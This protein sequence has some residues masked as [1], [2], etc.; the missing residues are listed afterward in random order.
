MN[1][2]FVVVTLFLSTQYNLPYPPTSLISVLTTENESR[3]NDNC[4]NPKILRLANEVVVS[5]SIE[6]RSEDLT[7]I[8]NS[9]RLLFQRDIHRSSGQSSSSRN[10]AARKAEPKAT[11]KVWNDGLSASP[12]VFD[13]QNSTFSVSGVHAILN[14]ERCGVCSLAG[15]TVRFSSSSI[16]STG[17]SSPFMVRMSG[18]EGMTTKDESI[19]VVGTGLS[20][21]STHLIGGTRPLFSFGLIEQSSSLAAS[22]CALR[23]RQADSCSEVMCVSESWELCLEAHEPRQRDRNDVAEL[24]GNVMCLTTSFSSCFR[25]PNTEFD[26]SFENHT[27]TELGRLNNV[28]S[29]VTSVTFTLCTFNEMTVVGGSGNGGAAIFLRQ[30]SSSLT[31]RT[32]FFL[33]CTCTASGIAGTIC[34]RCDSSKRRPF[35]VSDSSFTECSATQFAGSVFL[36]HSSSAAIDCCFFELSTSFWDGTALLGPNVLAPQWNPFLRRRV[37]TLHLVLAVQRLFLAHHPDGKDVFFSDNSS[38]EIT[39]DMVTFCDSS[40]RAPNVSFL[41]NQQSDSSLIPQV[42]QTAP[43]RATSVGVSID[44]NE[45]TVTVETEEAIKGTMGMLLDGSN[46]PRLVHAVIGDPSEVSTVTSVVIS[47]GANGILPSTTYTNR[48]STLAPFSPPIVESAKS[49]LLEEGN[50]TAF[51]LTGLYLEEGSYWMLFEKGGKEWNITLTRSDSTTLNGTAPLHPSTAEDRLEW[52]TVCWEF[53]ECHSERLALLRRHCHL[54]NRSQIIRTANWM[55]NFTPTQHEIRDHLEQSLPLSSLSKL[56]TSLEW[57]SRLVLGKDEITTTSFV[58]PKNAAERRSQAAKENMNWWLPLVISVSL[59]LV[60]V[61][62]VAIVCCRRTNHKQ[63]K[64]PDTPKQEMDVEDRVEVELERTL[65]VTEHEQNTSACAQTKVG[66]TTRRMGSPGQLR[67]RLNAEDKTPL[68]SGGVTQMALAGG[69]QDLWTA[70]AECEI[71]AKLTSD[72]MLIGGDETVQLKEW[73]GDAV[74]AKGVRARDG[75]LSNKERR[76]G[77]WTWIKEEFWGRPGVV[78]SGEWCCGV[79]GDRR[80]E[81]GWAGRDGDSAGDGRSAEWTDAE[82]IASCLS[83]DANDRPSLSSLVSSLECIEPDSGAITHTFIS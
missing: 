76:T 67:M 55:A 8:G 62:V 25:H 34:L 10:A 37:D 30:T 54:A 80:C 39:A 9:S 7:L 77:R 18:S 78:G 63:N 33:K 52:S 71:L 1:S 83:I 20:L 26:F 65:C 14:W 35:S 2:L 41:R 3:M 47:C 56:D 60:I 19:V 61:L 46:V 59:L 24:G 82:L 66:L 48:K 16:T 42:V 43:I 44:G 29:D 53:T 22:G 68:A 23:S 28:T 12:F 32:C 5:S 17:D 57:R 38:S 21:E 31:V 4:L 81:C 74:A 11:P 58:I 27:Q 13:V 72:W 49:A 64:K 6:I 70:Q 40:F 69:V 51:E 36:E 79:G 73:K 45:A 50:T 75:K 15:S